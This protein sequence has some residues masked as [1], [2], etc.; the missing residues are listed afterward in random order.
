MLPK[1]RATR[2]YR[3][4]N[5]VTHDY[6]F[7]DAHCIM[8]LLVIPLLSDTIATGMR[9]SGPCVES[10]VINS[11]VWYDHAKLKRSGRGVF[12]RRSERCGLSPLDLAPLEASLASCL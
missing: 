1:V 12:D 4:I 11:E 5:L 10:N 6:L 2:R 8:S 3:F 9:V 7:W